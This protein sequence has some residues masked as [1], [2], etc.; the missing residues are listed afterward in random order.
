MMR[1]VQVDGYGVMQVIGL[2]SW[3]TGHWV[4]D[5]SKWSFLAVKV[6]LVAL[7]ASGSKS[8][9]GADTR[10]FDKRDEQLSGQHSISQAH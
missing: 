10:R 5:R 8:E 3:S 4:I 1:A 7:S 9:C 6:A 2:V